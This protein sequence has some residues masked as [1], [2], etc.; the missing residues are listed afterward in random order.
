MSK[1]V[2]V[3]GLGSSLLR[4]RGELIKSWQSLGHDIIAFAPGKE[5]SSEL[6]QMGVDYHSINLNRTRLNPLAD[7]TLLFNLARLILIKKPD[8]LFLYTIKPVIYGSLASIVSPE[9][10][11]YSLITGLGYV[12]SGKSTGQSLLKKILIKLYKLALAKNEKVFFQNHDDSS[13]FLKLK[14]VKHEQVAHVNGSGVNIKSFT[15][16][17]LPDNP[18]SFLLVARL[19]KEKGFFEFVNAAS[20]IKRKSPQARFMLIGWSLDDSPSAIPEEEVL[21]WKEEGVVE[22]YDHTKDVRPFIARA[23]I[24]VLPSY[25]GEGLPRTILEAMAMGRPI[26]T[27]NVPGCRETV[28][29]GVNGYLVPK[30]NSKALAKA[31]ENFI[32]K[33]E[34]VSIMGSASRQIAVEKYDVDKVNLTIN[35][36]MGLI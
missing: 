22:V 8:Y 12:F 9:L 32:D 15:T 17:P 21:K 16:V 11:V 25:Y 34:L 36:K 3:A 29:E 23:G 14:L 1:I 13:Y 10:K 27:T 31:M 30:K 4:F 20:I 5:V 7:L 2:I 18:L 24:F 6:N 26:I 35:K 19:L 28:R 33:P